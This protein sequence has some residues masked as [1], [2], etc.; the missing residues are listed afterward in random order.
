MIE[1]ERTDVGYRLWVNEARTIL[2]RLYENGDM[3]VASRPRPGATW[4]LP[5]A[6]HEEPTR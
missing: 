3:E 2:V 1:L 4:G 5:I 6:V